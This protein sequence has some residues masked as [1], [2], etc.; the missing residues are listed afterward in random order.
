MPNNFNNFQQDQIHISK[1]ILDIEN[2]RLQEIQESEAGCIKEIIKHPNKKF[3]NLM[4]DICDNGL[5]PGEGLY[6]IPDNSIGNY[7]VLEGNRRVCALKLLHNPNLAEGLI[8][9]A[10]SKKLSDLSGQ[11]KADPIQVIQS[12]IFSDRLEADPWIVRKHQGE[13]GG[14]G[15]VHWKNPEKNRHDER[16]NKYV[17]ASTQYINHFIQN[18]TITKEEAREISL[19]TLNRIAEKHILRKLLSYEYDKNKHHFAILGDGVFFDIVHAEVIKLLCQKEIK[20]SDVYDEA[21]VMDVIYNRVIPAVQEGPE[22]KV[23]EELNDHMK[24]NLDWVNKTIINKPVTPITFPNLGESS[25]DEDSGSKS[26]DLTGT[27]NTGADVSGDQP[28]GDAAGNQDGGETSGGQA[29]GE[30]STDQAGSESTTGDQTDDEDTQQDSE[31]FQEEE[32]RILEQIDRTYAD[33]FRSIKSLVNNSKIEDDLKNII[34]RDI[35]DALKAYDAKAWKASIAMIGTTLEGVMLGTLLRSEV[36]IDVT[37]K[38]SSRALGEIQLFNPLII[39]ERAYI[40]EKISF[41][42]LR[43]WIAEIIPPT[44]EFDANNIQQFRNLI[45]PSVS[46]RNTNIQLNH[47]RVVHLLTACKLNVEIIINYEP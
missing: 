21:K 5:N 41:E 3:F 35:S 42:V 39:D 1:L 19:T 32:D 12:V 8:S 38:R 10:Q 40:L 9:K 17:S 18:N 16:L 23:I 30:T 6:L 34:K 46:L 20:V 31:D 36:L 43:K 4:E 25:A 22:P 13:N 37:N 33:I 7:I 14:R 11:F 45:H 15:V 2:P 24:N 44:R 47:T 28:G 29:G 27:T 26:S